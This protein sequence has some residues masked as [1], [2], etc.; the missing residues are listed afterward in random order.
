MK[1]RTEKTYDIII[2]GAGPAGLT[3]GANTALRGLKSLVLEKQETPGGLP[4]LLY[5]DK[6]VRDH[7][8]FPVGILGKELSRMLT[9]QARNAGAEIK[10]GEEA[11]GV[12]KNDNGS[13][14]AVTVEGTYEAKRV[15]LSTGIYN[16]PRKLKNLE[17]Y[18]GP[19]LHYKI[20][21]LEIFSKKKVVIVGGGDHAFDT[22]IQISNIA[23]STTILNKHRYPKAKESGVELA[24]K[25]GTQVLNN[26]EILRAFKDK[27]RVINRIQVFNSLE[28][29]KKILAVDA[30]F[31]AIG[32]EP[33]KH[34]LE[35]NGFRP[36]DDGSVKVDRSMQTSIK[37]IYAAGDVTG[38]VRLIS[39][40]CAEGIVAAVHAFEEI[41]RPYWIQ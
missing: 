12:E 41:R 13:I 10:L 14:E 15:I 35:N 29:E 17:G 30:L 24:R 9:M 36:R 23:E 40:A 5:P 39:T 37:G 27:Q 8:G 18:A 4:T 28:N 26:T 22:A 33:V 3:A 31:I 38:E 16:I 2:I 11:V 7:P 19:N 20:E 21:N 25:S 1:G 34:F 6:I 32:F